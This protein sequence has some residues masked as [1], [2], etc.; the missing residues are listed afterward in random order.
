MNYIILKQ[1]FVLNHLNSNRYI[2]MNL[3]DSQTI[4][5]FLTFSEPQNIFRNECKCH[6]ACHHNNQNHAFIKNAT[7]RIKS[8]SQGAHKVQEKVNEEITTHN[9][10]NVRGTTSLP[11]IIVMD[12]TGK[13]DSYD[14]ISISINKKRS[15][16][17]MN[18]TSEGQEILENNIKMEITGHKALILN[19]TAVTHKT[20][21]TN[22]DTIKNKTNLPETTPSHFSVVYFLEKNYIKGVNK[23]KDLLI[24]RVESKKAIDIKEALMRKFSSEFVSSDNN[25]SLNET[26][27]VLL[28][29][30]ERKSSGSFETAIQTSTN[31]AKKH[32]MQMKQMVNTDQESLVVNGIQNKESNNADVN[33]S[34]QGIDHALSKYKNVSTSNKAIRNLQTLLTTVDKKVEKEDESYNSVKS[35]IEKV[36][37]NQIKSFGGIKN[38]PKFTNIKNKKTNNG[39]QTV[40]PTNFTKESIKSSK[41]NYT[42]DFDIQSKIVD[43]GNFPP[44]T[45]VDRTISSEIMS[46]K[47]KLLIQE[48]LLVKNGTEGKIQNITIILNQS[49]VKRAISKQIV[50]DTEPTPTLATIKRSELNQVGTTQHHRAYFH[51]IQSHEITIAKPNEVETLKDNPST[52]TISKSP[53]SNKGLYETSFEMRSTSTSAKPELSATAHVISSSNS[54]LSPSVESF[55]LIRESPGSPTTRR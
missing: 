23:T 7:T 42:I 25:I 53:L 13:N 5:L 52:I 32:V 37:K 15:K 50:S 54:K 36:A 34:N 8:M 43:I 3:S 24:K 17:K 38:Y 10:Q 41:N 30:E 44:S 20:V 51:L 9:F 4:I 31:N 12:H 26:K 45:A 6:R 55:Q 1:T 35:Y 27:N 28:R 48:S 19:S 33:I 47:N 2:T 29:D 39:D 18:Q 21:I 49:P 22:L 11:T 46:H 14:S 40:T 16:G